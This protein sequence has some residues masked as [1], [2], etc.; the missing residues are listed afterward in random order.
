M[1]DR[2]YLRTLRAGVDFGVGDGVARMMDNLLYL[3]GDRQTRECLVVDPAWDVPAVLAA[4]EGDGF[5]V[6]GALVTHWHPDHVGGNMM[7]HDVQ[8]LPALLSARSVPVYVNE[9]DVDFVKLMT[10][11][12]DSDLRPVTNGHRV[13][14]GAVE[15]ECLH[16]PGHTRGS[17]CFRCG[18]ALIAGDTLFLEGCGR[19][20]LPGGDVEEMWRTLY[21]RLLALPADLVL[22]PGHDYAKRPPAPLAEVRRT[23]SALQAP[24]LSTFR[25]LWRA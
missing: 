18:Q 23:N 13:Q 9:G 20:D 21:E 2:L 10:G 16:T 22:Y 24:D 4:A 7:G 8:G 5:T 6:V 1:D 3:V 11:L 14:V 25:R 12:G 15:V 19:T 17:Q